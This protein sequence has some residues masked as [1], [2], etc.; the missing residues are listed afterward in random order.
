M[1]KKQKKNLNKRMKLLLQM[2]IMNNNNKKKMKIL[3]KI[4]SIGRVKGRVWM[5]MKVPRVIA[6][7]KKWFYKDKTARLPLSSKN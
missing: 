6:Q 2:K 3:W 7:Q 5:E 1:T 4:Q